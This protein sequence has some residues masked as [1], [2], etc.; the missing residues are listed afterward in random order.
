[1][2]P[3]HIT[4]IGYRTADRG[5][6]DLPEKA[7]AV[8]E[9]FESLGVAFTDD[10]CRSILVK[11]IYQLPGITVMDV[12]FIGISVIRYKITDFLFVSGQL[13]VVRIGSVF[14]YNT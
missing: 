10:I 5:A 6:S 4:V 3:R 14:C 1:M 9:K 8:T 12:V 11:Y 2:G 7:A 13:I